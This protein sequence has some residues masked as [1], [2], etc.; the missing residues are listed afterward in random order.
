MAKKYQD[1]SAQSRVCNEN[2]PSFTDIQPMVQ[3]RHPPAVMGQLYVKNPA[4]AFMKKFVHMVMIIQNQGW[5]Q[6]FFVGWAN[7]KKL[8][9]MT[10]AP[11]IYDFSHVFIHILKKL[12]KK[13]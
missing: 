12:G 3:S 6:E 11:K 5:I 1:L 9:K 4:N 7:L 8:E 13:S 2:Q 10:S